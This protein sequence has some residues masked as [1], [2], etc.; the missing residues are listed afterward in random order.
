MQYSD[1]YIGSFNLYE[2]KRLKQ[3]KPLCYD[4]EA[5]VDEM[6]EVKLNVK[7]LLRDIQHFRTPRYHIIRT[8]NGYQHKKS[9]DIIKGVAD[10]D[11]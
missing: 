5:T 1:K 9:V 3:F 10:S 8:R 4:D 6:E 7:E 11:I 2:Q